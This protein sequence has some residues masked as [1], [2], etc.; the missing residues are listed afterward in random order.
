MR[1]SVDILSL[2]RAG[3]GLALIAS[4][5]SAAYADRGERRRGEGRGGGLGDGQAFERRNQLPRGGNQV[6]PR[7]GDRT[8]RN[9]PG[10]GDFGPGRDFRDGR[11]DRRGGDFR[12]PRTH[13]PPVAIA[14]PTHPPRFDRRP[15]IKRPPVVVRPPRGGHRPPVFVGGRNHHRRW[16]HGHR[17]SW[18][19]RIG[20]NPRWHR[21]NHRWNHHWSTWDSRWQRRQNLYTSGVRIY[22][23]NGRWGSYWHRRYNYN[24]IYYPPYPFESDYYYAESDWD[25]TSQPA[26]H[27]MEADVENFLNLRSSPFAGGSANI[28]GQL[29]AGAVIPVLSVVRTDEGGMPWA[30]IPVEDIQE[31]ID[32]PRCAG[33]EYVFAALDYLK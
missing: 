22:I 13:R 3:L 10:R 20:S 5:S 11:R 19:I 8:G 31:F 16:D 14:P 26:P 9:F 6:S 12:P 15:I 32:D 7:M 29:P 17:S 24:Y 18:Q 1:S 21:H 30:M 25:Y 27:Y 23:D 28:C 2:L 33:E 4:L